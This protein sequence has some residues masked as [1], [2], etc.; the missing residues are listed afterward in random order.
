VP[1]RPWHQKLLAGL[2][3]LGGAGLVVVLA[4]ARMRGAGALAGLS[5]AMHL[6]WGVGGWL[7]AGVVA[8][9]GWWSWRKCTGREAW[10]VVGALWIALG[11]QLLLGLGGVKVGSIPA[12]GQLGMAAAADLAALGVWAWVVGAAVVGAGVGACLW[13]ALGPLPRAKAP[14]RAAKARRRPRA[15]RAGQP[16]PAPPPPPPKRNGWQLPPLELLTA[17]QPGESGPEPGEAQATS[18]LVEAKLRDFGVEGQ[19][20]AVAPGPVV[21]TYEFRPAPGIKISKVASLADD[22]ALNLKAPSIRIVAPIPGKAVIGIEVPNASREVVR[23]RELLASPAYQKAS[24]VLAVALGK[25]ILGRPVVEDLGAM[26]HLL[27]A[28]ATGS[29]KSVFIN[30]LVLSLLYRATPEELKLIMV[31]PKR[32]ELATYNDIPHLLHPVITSPTEAT[33]GLRWAVREMQRRYE[34][35]AETGTRNIQGYNTLAATEPERS[36]L[37]YIIVV[38]DELADLMMVSSKE[39]EALIT[40]LAQMARAAGIHLVVA[41]QRPSVDVITGLIKANFPARIS[42]KLASKADSRTILDAHGAEHLLG[43]GDMLFAPPGAMGLKRLHGAYVSDKEIEAV[44]EFWKSQGKARYEIDL[45]EQEEEDRPEQGEVDELYEEA[46]RLVKRSGQAS[47]S[48]LQRRLRI[49]YNR[50]ARMIEQME[51]EGIV[52]PS[53]GSRPREV[54]VRD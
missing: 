29:G 38:I 13:A 39:V 43:A 30:S 6:A 40:R 41:T 44:V 35:L 16:R 47:V 7:M 31:D 10:W 14:Q 53:D 9:G 24:T 42:F 23:L 21:T 2:M 18:R 26:P 11:V 17:A 46:V 45:A 4:A 19:I 36:Q 1:P 22:L 51:R 54:L 32:I 49:G 25:D 5:R 8:G 33:A 3:M 28:G 12:G 15:R 20:V 48:M 52:G 34:L 50:A 27:V 37:P